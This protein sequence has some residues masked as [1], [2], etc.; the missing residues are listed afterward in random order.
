MRNK[1]HVN[2][3]IHPITDLPLGLI[4]TNLFS[5]K[6]EKRARISYLY[7]T[8]T[9]YYLDCISTSYVVKAAA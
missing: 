4:Q 3:H 5:R 9:Y 6:R 8:A 2:S 7:S 1:E